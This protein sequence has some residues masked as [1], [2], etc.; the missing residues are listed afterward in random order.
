MDC[1]TELG[2][3]AVT[4][5]G[6]LVVELSMK[7]FKYL[8]QHK[9]ITINLEEE[10]KNLKMMKQALQTKV[11]NER[12]K[13]HEIDP[14]VQKW[15]SEVTIIENEWQ[16]W[17]SNENNVNK[18]KKC[19]GG[20]CSD[21]AF[22][23][24]L[25]KQATK[26][27]E[28][29]TSLKEEKNKFKDISYPKASLTLGSTFTK[30][31]KSLLSREKLITEVIEK[32]KDDQV[33]MISICGMGGVGKTTLVKEV[34][35]TIEKNNLFDEVVMAVVSQ[36]VNYEKIQIQIADIL[37]MEFKKAS[38]QGRAMELL[39]RLSE[40]KGV[41][42]VLDDVW[43]ILD[44]ERIGLQ[45]RDKYCKI[46]FTSRDQKVCQN[47][48]CKVNF[49]VSVLSE[50][51]AWSLFR[52]MAGDVVYKHDINPIA[53]EV[54]KACGGLPLAIVTVGRALSIE[55]KSAWEDTLKQLRN[56]QSS[57][58]SDV[59]KFVH[60]CIELS[61]KFLGN[62]E[63]KLF[64][65]LCGLFPEDFDIPIECLLH[66]AV[67]LGMFK[68]ITAS[69]EA[70]NQVHTLVN[71][72]KR[73]F[74]LLESN[75]QGCVKMHDIVRNVVISF[76]FKNE[77][78]KFMVQYNFKSLKE[79][80]LNDINAISLILDDTNKLESGLECPTLKL[81]QVRSKSKEPISWPELFFQGMCAFKVLSMQNLCIPKLSSLSQAS[82]SL[83]T[84]KVEHCDVGDISII[85][86]KL[87]LLEVLSLAHSNIKE[88]PV[89]IGDLGS[90]RLLD[91]TY[92]N[93][94][95]IISDNVLIRLFQLEELYFR[96]DN[97]SWNKNEVAINELKKISHQL[98]VVE[99][100]FR[101][102]EI[103]LKDLVFNNLQK[104]W[105]YVDRYSNFQRSSYLESNLLQV[106]SIGYQYV[107][108]ILM[109]SQVIK[110]C[111]ILAI[112][113]V[114]DL[115]NIISHLLSDYTIPYLKDLRVVSC[116]NL[117][118]LIDC[119][120]HCNGFPQIQSLSLNN[121]E[122]LKQ[123][124]YSSNHHEVKRLMNEFSYLGKMELTDLPSFI[125]F[126]NAI[127]FNEL[128]EVSK[129]LFFLL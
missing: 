32:L 44:F 106:S 10:L 80:K 128:N 118:Y 81:L 83:H 72:L 99:M 76:L 13:G 110:E 88:L 126:D 26:R 89:E 123:I 54:A 95:N 21:L 14:I 20:Q 51:E 77:E 92:C 86:K 37:G 5:L 67:G 41:L 124:C 119:T 48:G 93:D 27:I 74:L 127:E 49:Q 109:I 15:L 82:F 55:G 70:R 40:G 84:L 66:H 62:K 8:T 98:K 63:Y 11:D 43:D 22:N 73:K 29:I 117:E 38:L 17:I 101:G 100:K 59:E 120:V 42:I 19:F 90:L 4:K 46:L 78:D 52:E 112:E 61:L 104:F 7:H 103:L 71:N 30:D 122:T 107:N 85:G 97:F 16:K 50:D 36:D 79:E 1:L 2:K 105:V 12:R 47:M 9:K 115:K 87:V 64:L 28:Y 53:R 35:K 18:N 58:S 121:L 108:S 125:G 96:M 23:Y 57:S 24:S 75:V 6:Q 60:P 111:E 33:K 113:K 102:T 31:V 69:W 25:G 114:K 3:E 56:F 129:I 34:I 39:E 68:H 65:M 94:L 45:E 116:P 91:L